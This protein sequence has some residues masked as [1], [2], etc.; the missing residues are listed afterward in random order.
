[1]RNQL[2]VLSDL[3]EQISYNVPDIALHIHV[4]ELK[5]FHKHT[6]ACHWHPDIELC[7]PLKGGIDFF[8]NGEIYHVQAGQGIFV[9]SKRLHYSFSARQHNCTY[10]CMTMNPYAYAKEHG[11][12]S[13]FLEEKF[14]MANDDVILLTNEWELF[15]K[16]HKLH[17]STSDMLLMLSLAFEI[18]ATIYAKIKANPNNQLHSEHWM[19]IWKM[20]GFIHKNYA[21]KILIDDIALAGAVSHT[22][23]HELFNTNLNCTP[24]AYLTD[25]R[26]QKSCEILKNTSCLITEIAMRCG[27]QSSSYFTYVFRNET[28]MTPREYRNLR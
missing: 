21:D 1:M 11:A 19:T 12:L 16:I 26:I 5:N 20:T 14:G 15:S 23:C 2:D 25:Y 18:C 24:I 27:F 7:L 4:E 8:V 6:T 17:D 9:N 10:L 28:G 22:K 3:S 13:A